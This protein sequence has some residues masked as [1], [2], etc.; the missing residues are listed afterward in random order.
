MNTKFIG[1]A[2]IFRWTMK[3][4]CDLNTW[5]Y[6]KRVFQA[7]RMTL[8]KSELKNEEGSQAKDIFD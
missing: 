7:Q 5:K 8:E 4:L 1:K 3:H 2:D 6:E